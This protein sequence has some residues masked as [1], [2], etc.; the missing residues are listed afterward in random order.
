[1]KISEV[2]ERCGLSVKTV[3]YYEDTGIVVAKRRSNG[4]R[5]FGETEVRAL[6]LIGLARACGFS[7]EECTDILALY[8]TP[9][10]GRLKAARRVAGY[11]ERIDRRAAEILDLRAALVLFMFTGKA[12]TEDRPHLPDFEGADV[13]TRKQ[14]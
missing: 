12:S 10:H 3:R 7:L 9:K 11:L 14:P 2:A 6:R 5:E 13:A 8:K 4:Y 1:M